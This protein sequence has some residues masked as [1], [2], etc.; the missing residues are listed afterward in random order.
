MPDP[1][2]TQPTACLGGERWTLEELRVAA[3]RGR[4][5]ASETLDRVRE[6]DEFR[7]DGEPDTMTLVDFQPVSVDADPF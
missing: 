3:V 4:V 6:L 2:A 5:P 7:D 1:R